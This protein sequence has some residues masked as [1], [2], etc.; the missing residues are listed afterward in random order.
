MTYHVCQNCGRPLSNPVSMAR[1]F[2]PECAE[3]LGLLN[4]IGGREDGIRYSRPTRR[5]D[6]SFG[7]SQM[8]IWDFFL[9]PE[10]A[11]DVEIEEEETLCAS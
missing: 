11:T 5:R 7:P 6:G 1:G 10:V 9:V 4:G 3:R 8:S 2:G